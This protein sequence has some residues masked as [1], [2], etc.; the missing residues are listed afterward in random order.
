MTK[1]SRSMTDLRS[2]PCFI[3]QHKKDSQ[4]F[5]DYRSEAPHPSDFKGDK[6]M[7][8]EVG[9]VI[10][11]QRV[12]AGHDIDKD[13]AVRLGKLTNPKTRQPL[14]HRYMSI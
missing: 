12:K 5:E 8:F 4:K 2:D 11:N 14:F 1:F 6:S 3:E 9:N 7:R 10:D 13:S